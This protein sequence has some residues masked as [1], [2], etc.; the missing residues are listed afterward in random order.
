VLEQWQPSTS[1]RARAL[2]V[3]HRYAARDPEFARLFNAFTRDVLDERALPQAL[4]AI[5]EHGTVSLLNCQGE[6][7]TVRRLAGDVRQARHDALGEAR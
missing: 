7:L 5:L 1:Q 3:W 2:E 4:L 6:D